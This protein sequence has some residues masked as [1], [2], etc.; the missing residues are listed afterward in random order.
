MKKECATSFWK[1]A[2]KVL[3]SKANSDVHPTFSVGDA[4]QFFSN[5]YNSSPKNLPLPPW[6]PTPTEP[7]DH[8]DCDPIRADEV[9]SVIK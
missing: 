6:L 9:I 4:E 8:F 3:D 1:F 5:T 7:K 2:S